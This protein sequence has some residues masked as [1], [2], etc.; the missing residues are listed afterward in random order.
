MFQK[1]KFFQRN[2]RLDLENEVNRFISDKKVINISYS[3]CEVGYSN[4]H[5]CCVLYID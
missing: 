5:Y 2:S 4:Y 3:V 1:V